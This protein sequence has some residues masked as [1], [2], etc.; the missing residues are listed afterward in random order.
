MLA[1]HVGERSIGSTPVSTKMFL[2]STN[3]GRPAK[4][5]VLIEAKPVEI[6]KVRLF[7]I[8]SIQ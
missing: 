4:V 3:V 6:R 2:P 7:M 1:Y 8:T 5:E